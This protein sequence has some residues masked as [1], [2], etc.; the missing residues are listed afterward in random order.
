MLAPKKAYRVAQK[1]KLLYCDQQ[2]T[3][4][5]ATLYM[6]PLCPY[7]RLS[8]FT[9]RCSTKMAKPRI[10][11]TTPFYSPGNLVY[12]SQRSRRNPDEITRTGRQI[13]VGKIKTAIFDQYLAIYQKR[14][15]IQ[16]WTRMCSVEWCYFQ[17]PWVNLTI[18]N[19]R[20]FDILYRLSYLRSDWR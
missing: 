6:L 7:V 9:R 15:K 5:W 1:S 19:H 2:L 12:S 14:C 13:E 3:F 17:W 11:Q 20:I 18:P 10:I 8:V 4:F 16:K